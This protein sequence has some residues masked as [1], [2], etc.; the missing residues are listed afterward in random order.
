M[1]GS[2]S[3]QHLAPALL[4]LATALARAIP[5][6]LTSARGR[7][8]QHAAPTTLRIQSLQTPAAWQEGV[9]GAFSDEALREDARLRF[10]RLARAAIAVGV[11]LVVYLVVAVVQRFPWWSILLAA[12][13]LAL[14]VRQLQQGRK[15]W[16]DIDPK[17]PNAALGSLVVRGNLDDVVQF[18]LFALRGIGARVVNLGDG[19]VVA[20]TGVALG[21]LWLGNRLQISLL[22]HEDVV[23][24]TVR[25]SKLDYLTRDTTRRDVTRFLELW[26]DPPHTEALASGTT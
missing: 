3:F 4:A 15:V 5:P 13:L 18:T 14:L 7:A 1:T 12:L 2:V 22:P 20:G 26:A 10:R 25:S 24:V 16:G 21:R 6:L 17:S 9:E 19:L 23:R 11:L 8:G